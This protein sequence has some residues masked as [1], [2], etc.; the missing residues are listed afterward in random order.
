MQNLLIRAR[1]TNTAATIEL[2]ALDTVW[3]VP[4]NTTSISFRS[5][6]KVSLPWGLEEIVY[7]E[8]APVTDSEIAGAEIDLDYV[9][10]D[11][12]SAALRE[13]I[14]LAIGMSIGDDK[15][16]DWKPVPGDIGRYACGNV[17]AEVL[18]IEARIE[19]AR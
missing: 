9:R 11:S 14:N 18:R 7:A 17:V 13:A 8:S 5:E 4:N 19:V 15:V 1:R 16:D 12:S 3:T 2:P 6:I 10:R